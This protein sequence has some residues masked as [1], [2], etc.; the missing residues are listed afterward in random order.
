MTQPT[1]TTFE[2]LAIDSVLGMGGG[3]VLDFTNRT[4]AMFF[5]DLRIDIDEE[6][7]EGS[8]A[9]RLRDFLRSSQPGRV[10]TVLTALLEHRGDREGDEESRDLAKYKS[11]VGRLSSSGVA[12]SVATA[13]TDILSLA[14][15][16]ELNNKTNQ[17]LTAGDFDGAIT[18]ART[19]LESVLVEIEE[20]LTGRRQDHKRDLQGQF[21][22]VRKL[23]RIDE[24]RADLDANFK[25]VI[26]GLV[27]VVNGL[28]PLR[29]KMGDGHA[30]ERKPAAHHARFVVN[31]A[32]TVA[33]FLVESYLYQSERGL[34]ATQSTKGAT[35]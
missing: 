26:K 18:T 30:R 7:P 22:V 3:Y 9:N 6:F 2:L 25:T 11:V 16:A 4:F 17:R 13:Q 23:M 31:A 19:L 29:N 5:A 1:V 28:A 14:Y 12:F 8:K 21:T 27:Q 35:G 32:K 20:R 10:A 34:L 24:E 15:V 33:S